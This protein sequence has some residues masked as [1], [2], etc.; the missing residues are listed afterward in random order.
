MVFG[1]RLLR[2]GA[3]NREPSLNIALSFVLAIQNAAPAETLHSTKFLIDR[4]WR[5]AGIPR[6]TAILHIADFGSRERTGNSGA[7]P[8]LPA[9]P[10]N[11]GYPL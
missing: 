9:P 10:A 5:Q 2:Q 6:M 7:L 3:A 1:G 4:N 8:P 11:V